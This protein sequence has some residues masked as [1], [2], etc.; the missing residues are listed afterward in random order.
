MIAFKSIKAKMLAGFSVVIVMTLFLGAFVFYTINNMNTA[1]EEIVEQE[2]PLLIAEEQLAYLMSSGLAASRGYVI[3]GDPLYKES[4]DDYFNRSI[5]HQDTILEL[6][7][8][9]E[10]YEFILQRTNEWRVFTQDKV[11]EEYDNGNEQ[12]AFVNLTIS[13]DMASRVM[14][15]YEEAAKERE[16]IIIA[17]E[18]SVLD[19][20]KIT[21]FV[22]GGVVVVVFLF[23]VIIAIRTSNSVANPLNLV[24]ERMEILAEGG[25]DEKPL[26]TKLKD[27]LGQLIRSINDVTSNMHR[28][29]SEVN[30]VSSTVSNQS[31]ELMQSAH[32]V[33][34]GTEQISVTMEDLSIGSE[35]QANNASNLSSL[36]ESFVVK[37][38]EVDENGNY[39]LNN[40]HEVLEMA[41]EGRK[42]ME[43][44]T[45]QMLLID[46]I[47]SKAVESVQGLDK[48][49]QEISELVNV[50]NGIAEQTNLLALNA[51]IEAARAG[52]H[53]K[54]FSV[55]ADEVRKLSEQSAKSVMSITEIVKRIQS[56]S[57]SVASSLQNGYKEVERGTR[58]M[59]STGETFESI[60]GA[61]AT[62][63]NRIQLVANHLSA[64]TA[65][66]QEMS[67]AIQ[68]IAAISEQ[69]AA[70]IEETS[71]SAQQSSSSMVDVA[72]NA[73]DLSKLAGELDRLI[74]QFKL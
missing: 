10:V 38:M 48:H 65:D 13:Q 73:D 36:M 21:L 39:I 42:L 37:I 69:S 47:V 74:Q 43:V 33:R 30:N 26:T 6:A 71:A 20:G 19:N 45:E 51:A 22:V 64:L 46:T 59:R 32:E 54:G 12:M 27:E 63:A 18:V 58:H 2:L 23:S 11:F 4:F 56:E 44:T 34:A 17:K 67:N 15:E 70:G 66:S 50:I 14:N 31:E 61:N 55:V 40:S 41:K 25:L 35:S 29:L 62:M 53:G 7:E 24:V 5:E 28:V 9:T 60:N 16:E 8:T 57:S 1:T 68:E 3:S 52:E 49:S 72:N